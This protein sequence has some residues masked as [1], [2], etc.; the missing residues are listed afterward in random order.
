MVI[1]KTISCTILMVTVKFEFV[2]AFSAKLCNYVLIITAM[3]NMLYHFGPWT[4]F[5]VKVISHKYFTNNIY[6]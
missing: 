1:A 3:N 2:E 4:T 6:A 5:F